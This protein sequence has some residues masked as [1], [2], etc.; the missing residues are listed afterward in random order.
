[1]AEEWHVR[2]QGPR[3]T[4]KPGGGQRQS[5]ALAGPDDRDPGGVDIGPVER[6]V[7]RQDGIG[8]EGGLSSGCALAGMDGLADGSALRAPIVAL[9]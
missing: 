9:A 4:I 3:T 6:R 8:D 1:V 2:D 5:T 7:D